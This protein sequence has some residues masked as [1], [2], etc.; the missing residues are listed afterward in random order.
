MKIN[1]PCVVIAPNKKKLYKSYI[2]RQERI[3]SY[4]VC[5]HT[6]KPR[7]IW[8]HRYYGQLALSLGKES[9]Y[10]FSKF[11]PLN[12]DTPF[13]RALSMVLSLSLWRRFD[14]TLYFTLYWD[15]D[16]TGLYQDVIVQHN[17]I[18]YP[19]SSAAICYL[20]SWLYREVDL[21]RCTV[22][23]ISGKWNCG[24]RVMNWFHYQPFFERKRNQTLALALCSNC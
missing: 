15:G 6:V 13:I 22:R 4:V 23:N 11:N 16:Y 3:L 17:T 2:G 1:L 7:L 18:R 24:S 21:I 14:C 12:T 20:I 5:F 19:S 9:P 8:T 10:I